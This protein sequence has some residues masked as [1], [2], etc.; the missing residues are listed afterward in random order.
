[1]LK[2]N[3]YY[4]NN[5]F[6]SRGEEVKDYIQRVFENSC[7]YYTDNYYRRGM[8]RSIVNQEL[9]CLVSGIQ[10]L[11][12]YLYYYNKFYP[13]DFDNVFNN[14]ISKLEIV[15]VLPRNNREIYGR[16]LEEEKLIYLNPNL[17]SSATLTGKERTRL[18][19]CHELGHIINS[20]WLCTASRYIDEANEPTSIKQLMYNGLSLI[21]EATTQNRAE[22]ITY[23]FAGKMRPTFKFYR[24]NGL[25]DGEIYSSNFDFY[26]ELQE[27]AIT[28]GRT[29]RGIGKVLTNE[30]VMKQLSIRTLDRRFVDRLFHEYRNDNVL[31]DLYFILTYM[32]VIKNASYAMFG[33]ADRKYIPMSKMSKDS[34]NKIAGPLRDW[35]EPYHY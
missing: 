28:F 1:M 30:E 27:P 10:Y 32:G 15:T 5:K 34:L 14:L 7:I 4:L 8:D 18:Y 20:D 29:L 31:S 23:Y 24:K 9:E 22:A 13:N 17:T 11:E 2:N 33:Y 6:S 16:F 3:V 25:F 26:G 35:R 21:D 19:M 12:D